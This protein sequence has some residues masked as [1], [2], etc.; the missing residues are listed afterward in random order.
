[1]YMVI[2]HWPSTVIQLVG[3]SSFME[4]KFHLLQTG[5]YGVYRA[6]SLGIILTQV[7]WSLVGYD[8]INCKTKLG[9]CLTF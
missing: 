1:M 8:T 4:G 6:Q 5:F 2:R 9:L 3:T 7:G